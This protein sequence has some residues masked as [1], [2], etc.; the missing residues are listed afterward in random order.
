[1]DNNIS[2]NTYLYK[3]HIQS[4]AAAIEN[5]LL[6]ATE[7][8]IGTCW[9]CNLRRPRL[10]KKQLHIPHNFDIIAYITL[11]YPQKDDSVLSIS[12]YKDKE[13]Y[14]NH[15]RKYNLEQV[16]CNE[17]FSKIS[18]DCTEIKHKKYGQ[19]IKYLYKLNVPFINKIENKL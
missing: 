5:I 8:G 18:G 16:L 12:H 13:S 2:Y 1:M 15:K 17:Y 14:I 6:T 9:I 7:L 4:A 3:D 11:G 19:F 10:L